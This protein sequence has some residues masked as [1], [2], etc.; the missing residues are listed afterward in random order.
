MYCGLSVAFAAY[1]LHVF[2]LDRRVHT[3]PQWLAVMVTVVVGLLF[4]VWYQ[5][6]CGVINWL[7][8]PH[9]APTPPGGIGDL[10]FFG[11]LFG[12]IIAGM[13]M[14]LLLW[15]ATRSWKV[16][17]ALLA[18]SLV[19]GVLTLPTNGMASILWNIGFAAVLYAWAC[20]RP[21]SWQDPA[22]CEHCGYSLYGLSAAVCPECGKP[23]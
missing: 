17:L 22:V 7:H 16:L 13:G 21:L 19:C 15:A 5:P 10:G 8:N 6:L 12:T 4:F 20:R 2:L 1:V 18:V 23:V 14:S 3:R 11:I 9:P